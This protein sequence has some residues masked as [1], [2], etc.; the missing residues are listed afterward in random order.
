VVLKE[1]PLATAIAYVAAA[2]I[3]IWVI[4]FGYLLSMGSK[5]SGLRRQVEVL[6]EA[7]ERKEKSVGT[8]A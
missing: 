8:R 6:T 7:V 5:L 4:L 2:Y 3:G 1:V